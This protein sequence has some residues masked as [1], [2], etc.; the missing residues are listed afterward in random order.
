ML[1]SKTRIA[2]HGLKETS[3]QC[4]TLPTLG[5]WGS[6]CNHFRLQMNFDLLLTIFKFYDVEVWWTQ[7]CWGWGIHSWP[8]L[9]NAHYGH[10]ML[11]Y[12]RSM[13]FRQTKLKFMCWW[14]V[15]DYP[16]KSFDNRC[17]QGV[18]LRWAGM[19][20]SINWLCVTLKFMLWI[21]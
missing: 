4:S 2:A 18:V 6:L 19:G 16:H 20:Y 17:S 10:V 15:I 1:F 14:L 11:T 12:M 8:S 5:R 21:L 7:V 3:C 13:V 9:F